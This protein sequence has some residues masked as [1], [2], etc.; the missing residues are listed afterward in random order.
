MAVKHGHGTFNCMKRSLSE[1][2][3]DQGKNS[4]NSASLERIRA[5][6]D[7]LCAQIG[8]RRAGS[9]GDRAAADYILKQFQVAG[10]SCVHLEEFSCVSVVRSEAEIAIG[11]KGA[12]RNIPARVLAGSPSTRGETPIETDLVWVEMPEQA[13]RLL[14]ASLRGKVIVLIGPMPTRADL[15]RRLLACR[16]AAVVHV[17]DRLPFDWVKDDGVYPAWVR[18]FGMPPTVTIPYREAW[19]LRKA[20][21]LRA[22]VRAV[23][24][25]K[26]AR[27]HNVVAEIPGRE[28]K[29][30][31]VLVGAHHDTQ[32]HNTGA[33]DNASGVVALLELARLLLGG[34][35]PLR[36][37]RLVSFGAEEQLSVGS[38]LYVKEHRGD[39]GSIGAVINLD[40]VS[41]PLGH[42]WSITAGRKEFGAWMLKNLSRHGLDT[43]EKPSP[44]PFADHFPFSAFGVPA[45]TLMRPNMDGGMRWQHHSASDSL[46]NV[47]GTELAKVI[48]AVAG[49]TN[50]LARTLRWPFGRGVAP[51]HQSETRRL[52]RELFGF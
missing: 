43:V 9:Q 2:S 45:L 10:L 39:M 6:W 18:R 33:D 40:S 16:P 29:L 22:R 51:E 46:E 34:T 20:G 12:L 11:N 26:K 4:A 5:H 42:H 3:S 49:V 1:L 41:S 24:E 30:P 48:G 36:T 38:S 32:C 14:K 31:L 13:E 15:H 27:S 37:V 23:A 25:L 28:S 17:D 7:V 50:S 52:A 47:S 8:E 19:D 44:M 21:A 35:R